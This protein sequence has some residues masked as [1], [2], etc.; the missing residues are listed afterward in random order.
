MIW[1]M[2]LLYVAHQDSGVFPLYNIANTL[3]NDSKAGQDSRARNYALVN[4]AYR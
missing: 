2:L 1:Q 3:G 4:V